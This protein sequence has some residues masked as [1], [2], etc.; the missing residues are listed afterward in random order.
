MKKVI[1]GMSGG[2]DSS[3]AAYLL[4][5]QGY[6]VI[7]VFM[8]NWDPYLNKDSTFSQ[9]VDSKCEAEQEFEVAS[10]IAKHL[11]IPIYRV[12]FIKDYWTMVFEPFLEQYSKGLTPNP[13]VLCNKHIKF[14]AF[15]KYCFENFDVDY[16]ATGHYA[17][18]K[19]ND[20]NN[21]YELIEA[22]DT[23]KDQTYFLCSLNQ[24]Q[25][26]KTLFPL[27]DYTKQEIREIAKL[28]G[29]DNWNKKDSTGICFIGERN[30][31]QFIS[32]YI[33]NKKGDIIDIKTNLKMGSHNGIHLYTIGQRKG[34]NLSGNDSRYFV[35]KKDVEKNILYVTN[36]ENENEF[37]MN[38]KVISYD[39][40]WISKIPKKDNTVELRFRHTQQKIGGKFEIIKDNEVL[41][42]FD[43][44]SKAISMGQYIVAYKNGICLGGGTIDKVFN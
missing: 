4:K 39:F 36:I 23:H 22:K 38:S 3:V 1:V 43:K 8:Q 15:H 6:D 7:G 28:N 20:E 16:I 2:V 42:M 37:L 12:N 44:K 31:K 11:D 14:G 32:N 10:A 40:N 29:L 5:K 33:E 27:G 17:K 18:V 21:I 41:F 9:N 13:D 26:S 24:K 34:L 25:L 30:F 19:F 35:C